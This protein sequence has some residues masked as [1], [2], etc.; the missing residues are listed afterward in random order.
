MRH[1]EHN[2][3]HRGEGHQ[4]DNKLVAFEIHL[5]M[6]RLTYHTCGL[7][8]ILVRTVHQLII[9]KKITVRWLLLLFDLISTLSIYRKSF[10]QVWKKLVFWATTFLFSFSVPFSFIRI[11]LFEAA[12]IVFNFSIWNLYLEWKSLN[13]FTCLI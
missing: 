6:G 7:I 8:F 13:R 10:D 4:S 1:I 11:I 12:L 2:K 9:G 5:L 3:E